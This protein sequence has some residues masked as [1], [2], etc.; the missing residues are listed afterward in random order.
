MADLHPINR[1]L[2][3]L[4]ENQVTR[5][6]AAFDGLDD[7]CVD[8]DPGGDCNTIRKIA[9]HLLFLRRFQLML[10]GSPHESKVV[11]EA[12]ITTFDE[13]REHLG[14]AT[15]LVAAALREHDPDDW[16]REPTE[17]DAER[18]GPWAD[19]PTLVRLVKPMNDF[20]NHL[21]SIRA[22]RRLQGR[23]AERTQ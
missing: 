6:D 14:A 4:L 21:G 15:E 13:L 9:S 18:P 2:L 17:T 12:N 8:A 16:H 22:I 19:K 11:D 3:T 1:T 10:L 5:T 20:T 7:E 23:P